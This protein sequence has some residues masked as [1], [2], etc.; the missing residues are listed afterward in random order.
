MEICAK[1]VELTQ[2]DP[3]VARKVAEAYRSADPAVKQAAEEAQR[4]M[5]R[6]WA[7]SL[8]PLAAQATKPELRLVLKEFVDELETGT[9][10]TFVTVKLMNQC[11][12]ISVMPS[13]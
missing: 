3:E 8:E 1:V 13:P 11:G 9:P 7:T 2:P 4:E 10:N 5:Y 12:R 6:G